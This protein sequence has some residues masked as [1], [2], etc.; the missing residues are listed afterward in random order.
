MNYRN[1]KIYKIISPHTTLVY[2]G[3]TSTELSKRFY[4]HK[5]NFKTYVSGGNVGR[6]TSFEIIDKGDAQIILIENYP[7]DNKDQ[8]TARERHWAE[9]LPN[10][11]NLRPTGTR[12]LTV[13]FWQFLYTQLVPLQPGQR[14]TRRP[15]VF[16]IHK[17]KMEQTLME[18][19]K[20]KKFNF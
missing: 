4:Q 10:C 1:G 15:T 16:S 7:C 8:L 6:L 9:T 2:V 12:E 13:S 20:R 5:S 11:V 17:K 18:I 3:S 14:C 19:R